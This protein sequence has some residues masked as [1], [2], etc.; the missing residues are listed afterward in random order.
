MARITDRLVAKTAATAT[1]PGMYA[2]GNGLYLRVAPGGSKSWILRY[3]HSGRRHDIGLGPYPL[4]GLA[5]ARQRANQRRRLLVD[6]IDP[7]SERRAQRAAAAVERIKA[8]T[9]RQ[10]AESYID[11]HAAGWRGGKQAAQWRHSLTAY[12]FPLLGELPV[13]A[14]DTAAVL[15]VLEPIWKTKTETATRVRE[16]IEAVLNAATAGGYRTGDNPARWR[17]HLDNLL[18]KRSRVQRV[19]HFPALPYPEIAAFMAELR[20]D[21]SIAARALEF[22]ILTAARSSEVLQAR[23]DEID[24]PSRLWTVPAERAKSGR[25]HRVPLSDA[26]MAIVQAMAKIRLNDHVFPGRGGAASRTSMFEQLRKLG[27]ADLTT[28][29]FRST[30]RDWAAERTNFP[31]EVA[32]MALAHAVGDKVEAAYRRGDLFQKRRQIM[33]A[34]ARFC[35]AAPT[36]SA[37][38]P[39]RRGG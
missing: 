20:A 22:L 29:G 9:L 5:D 4:I 11:T 26:A 35:I 34:W 14:I 32:E 23:W 27:R 3:R 28:H 37:V 38:V 33:D 21:T 25:E 17:G 24:L 36:G 19:S 18:P 39:I 13:Q 30:F 6:G 31:A 7:L 2:D 1:Q 12:V 8:I 15:S 16:R 10:A